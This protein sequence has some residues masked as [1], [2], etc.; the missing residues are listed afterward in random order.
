LYII[1]L[2]RWNIT[3]GIPA[4]PYTDADY[5]MADSNIIGINH[6]LE[7]A[8]TAGYSKA[9]LPKGEY[10]L[11]FPR[12]IK[13]VSN[14]TFDLN[15]SILKVIYDSDRKS[16]FDTRTTTDYYNFKGNSIEFDNVHNS[17]LIGGT[18]IG[19]R[20]D[21]SFSNVAAERKMEHTYGVVFNRSTKYSSIKN[22]VVRDYM[23]DNITFSSSAVRELAEFNLNLSQNNLDYA[24][25]QVISAA[26]TLTTGFIAI[27]QDTNISTFLIAGAG[28]SRLTALMTKEVDVFFFRADNTFIGVLKKRRIYTDI[29]IPVG[30]A[31]MRMVFFN[32]TNPS[33]NMQITLKFGSIPHH[34]LVEYNEVF[35]GHRGGISLGGSYN[36]IQHN[37]IRDNG[38]GS[39]SFLDG[40]PIF[41]D[42]TRYG[43]NQEDSFGDNCVI[44][45]NLIYGSNHG[46]LA[47]CY[48]IQIENNH[49]YNIDSIG[50][51][52]YSLLFANI[53]GNVLSNC[54]TNIGLMTSHFA[55]AYV[56]ISENSF[57]GGNMSF[58]ANNTYQVT[59]TNNNFVDVPGMNLGID[60]IKCVFKQN[61][62]KYSTLTSTPFITAYSIEDCIIESSSPKELVLRVYHQSGCTFKNLTITLQTQNGT[63]QGESV[64]IDNCE[65]L[66]STV[67][68]LILATKERYVKITRSIF[69]DT[70]IKAGNINTAGKIATILLEDC[71]LKVIANK[72]LFATDLNQPK[73]L[74]E[75]RN[76]SIEIDNADFSYLIHHDKPI[77]IKVFDISLY[78]NN[79][80][81]KGESPLTLN[82]Y[83]HIKPMEIF[84]S[85]DNDFQNILLPQ[86]DPAIFL[87]YNPQTTF[88]TEVTLQEETLVVH[89]LN[90]EYPFI[91]IFSDTKTM[92]QPLIKVVD[93][94]SIL[95]QDS[96]PQKVQVVVT[97]I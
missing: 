9:I 66:N 86:P 92:I 37:V 39:N 61:R 15:G 69:T 41:S 59:V 45:N 65:Y 42:P 25:G 77:V 70:I 10:A 27:P 32:E 21:R 4:K 43:I 24:T 97:K 76:C 74:I 90:T 56:N 83:N 48:S 28:Y 82:Y 81:Y 47:G 60:P 14:L 38:K 29:S 71:Q 95:L 94:N 3:Q 55:N 33:K 19:D 78:K 49:I 11:C 46:I 1:E 58:F 7:H 8:R 31:K 89:N 54:T 63:T 2:Q 87:D 52:L 23:G 84:I 96:Q 36:I 6:A 88:K 30:A 75:V 93:S 57:T 35:N 67:F 16:P 34:N 5:R 85:A 44:R 64:F 68:N 91:L 17:H 79:F 26:N 12:V 22:C 53:R 13:M 62:I 80:V 51:N 18:I 40:K 72:Y 20:D 73:A 50:I